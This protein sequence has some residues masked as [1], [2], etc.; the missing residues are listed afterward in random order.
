MNKQSIFILFILMLVGCKHPNGN[1]GNTATTTRVN[2]LEEPNFKEFVKNFCSDSCFQINHISFP[3]EVILR[4][5]DIDEEEDS[6]S[7]IDKNEWKYGDLFN[8]GYEEKVITS[9]DADNNTVLIRGYDC[10]IHVTYMFKHINGTWT[11]YKIDDG[12]M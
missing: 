11:L 10:G 12:S 4:G 6:V 1:G 7:Y 2:K 8:P 3:L 5:N 9:I